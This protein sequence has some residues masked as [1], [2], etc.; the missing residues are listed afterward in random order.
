MLRLTYPFL[1]LLTLLCSLGAAVPARQ[2]NILIILA[3][4]LGFSD[5][6]CYGGDIAT[7]NLDALARDGVRFTQFYNTARCWPSRAAVMTG[8]YAQQVRRDTVPGIASGGR[9]VRPSW[10]PLMTEFL[11]PAGYRT[12]H[13]GK[14]HIDGQPLQNGFDRSLEIRGGQNN[15]FKAAGIFEEGQPCMQTPDYYVTTATAD[16]A[17]RCLS[18]HAEKFRDLPFFHYLCFTA[19][20][21]PLQAPAADIAK[22]R[23]VYLKGWN[24]TAAERHARMTKLG[25]VT[26]ALPPMERD[27]GPPYA[28]PD[29]VAKLGP[30]EVNRPIPWAELNDAQR[31][32]QA[33]KMA[34]HAAMVD[35]MDQE[36]GRVLAQLKAM[37]AFENTLI[38]FAS[39]N[40]ASAE[41]MVRG[42]GHDPA[43]PMGSAKSFLCLGPGWSSSSNTPLRRHKTWV[44]EGGI[45]TPLIAHWPAGIAARGE[46]RHTPAHLIDIMPTVLEL[47]G[48]RKPAT[49]N[50]QPVPPAPGRS[51]ASALA[52]DTTVAHDFLWWE[53]E[54][55]RAIRAGDW[56]LVTLAKGN[57]ELY[58]LSRDRGEQNNLASARPDKVRELET[59]W[60]QQLEATIKLALS[61][62]PAAEPAPKKV[63]RAKQNE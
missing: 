51:L 31:R 33:T 60:N 24:V 47:A 63:R 21:F 1:V 54:G 13:S 38:L 2:P 48:V 41:M 28:F 59:M 53:H 62:P 25:L 40:G 50:N 49:I 6:G 42:D 36:I 32:F 23:D 14:W 4:D 9:G 30:D 39:D 7:P 29:D 45:S 3:D 61:D 34:I 57:W 43:A 20:H 26:H 15:F 56:K 27:V 19:P 17:V 10:A 18:E 35:R 12:Y 44:H 22:Y 16:H 58:D 5:V 11:R 52:R 46:L 8:Y 37:G 55:N